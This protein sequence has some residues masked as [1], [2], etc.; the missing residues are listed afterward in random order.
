M[1]KNIRQILL[2]ILFLSLCLAAA[3]SGPP[4]K[5]DINYTNPIIELKKDSLD[6]LSDSLSYFNKF[7]TFDK[8]QFEYFDTANMPSFPE[9]II[10]SD[11]I[12]KIMTDSGLVVIG[13]DELNSI[14]SQKLPEEIDL[15]SREITSWGKSI[16]IEEGERVH[17]DVV[18]VSGDA[19][20]KG[21]VNGD[22]VVING[23]I[24]VA[25]SGYI[26][27][28]AFTI[29]G[30][31]KKEE[32]AKIT[33]STIPFSVISLKH[34]Y[35]SVYQVIQSILLLAIIINLI[36]SVLA[37]SVFP[38]PLNRITNKLSDRPFKSFAFGYLFYIGAFLAWLLLLV[39][40]IGIPLA[41]LGEPVILIILLIISHIAINQIIGIRVFRK[42]GMFRSF[43]YGNLVTAGIPLVLLIIGLITN[44]LVFFILNMTLLGFLLFIILPL[45][46]GAACLARFGFPPKINK[47]DP[48]E[49]QISLDSRPTE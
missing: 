36:L 33:G 8:F 24:Y 35:N 5:E 44:S 21:Y 13:V 1:F 40:V 45:G 27:G 6:L 39:S 41:V 14:L 3:Y 22:V 49:Q 7:D 23:N 20:I 4:D 9:I 34:D 32:G 28:D 47:D 12:V 38:R 31:V 18:V 48:A 25:S 11:G 17:A 2:V 37:L 15:G 16:V 42:K 10:E 46:F 30:R 26:H 19:T 29:G 43:W